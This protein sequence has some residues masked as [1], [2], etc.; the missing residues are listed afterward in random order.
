MSELQHPYAGSIRTTRRIIGFCAAVILLLLVM[1]AAG[2]KQNHWAFLICYVVAASV[3]VLCLIL[4]PILRY[5]GGKE[6]K[7][8]RELV[9][10]NHW[11]RWQYSQDEWQSFTE[12]EWARTKRKVKTAPLQTLAGGLVI[13]LL[14]AWSAKDVTLGQGLIFGFVLGIPI[15]ILIAVTT[16]LTGKSTYKKR[17]SAAGEVYIGPKGVYQDGSYSTW[18]Q[19]GMKLNEVKLEPGDPSVVHFEIKG[20]RGAIQE[21]RV[22]VPRGREQEATELVQRFSTRT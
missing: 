6:L 11:A 9:E 8:I 13:G 1:L 17:L 3:L 15:G 4:L 16:Y 12:R 14:L 21:V 10:G 19:F 5:T 2:V 7:G 20:H 18:D 22:A